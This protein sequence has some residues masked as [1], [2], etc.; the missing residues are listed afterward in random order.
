MYF[1]RT[2]LIEVICE[3]LF[4]SQ[5]KII[6]NTFLTSTVIQIKGLTAVFLNRFFRVE[7]YHSVIME[8]S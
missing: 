1:V 5:E 3:L 2:Q 8:F 7:Q 4:R 6:L